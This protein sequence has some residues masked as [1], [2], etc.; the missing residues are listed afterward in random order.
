MHE[1]TRQANSWGR[2]SIVHCKVVE[3]IDGRRTTAGT[4]QSRREHATY[5]L[6]AARGWH[7]E[8]NVS[9]AELSSKEQEDNGAFVLATT[10]SRPPRTFN[11]SVPRPI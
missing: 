1:P 8:E 9:I 6:T 4:S 3:W 5:V 10:W 2:R 11:C 7:H